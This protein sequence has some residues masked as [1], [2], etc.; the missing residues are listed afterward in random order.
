M[1][2][3]DRLINTKKNNN[4]LSKEGLLFDSSSDVSKFFFDGAEVKKLLN[5]SFLSYKNI[6]YVCDK[7][8]DNTLIANYFY[9]LSNLYGSTIVDNIETDIE[10]FNNRISIIPNPSINEIVKIFEYILCGYKSFVFGLNLSSNLKLIN[11][12]KTIIAINYPNLTEVNINTLLGFSNSLFV[13]VSVNDDGLYYVSE[14]NELI[15]DN[16]ELNLNN[17]FSVKKDI[18]VQE[19]E[20]I[21]AE[22]KKDILV[23]INTDKEEDMQYSQNRGEQ[24]LPIKAKSEYYIE[25]EIIEDD[26][27]A[28]EIKET[29][30]NFN[31][32]QQEVISVL[33]EDIENCSS[34]FQENK[35]QSKVNKYKLLKEKVKNKRNI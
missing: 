20:N 34:D 35:V 12:L 33:N 14:I 25:E 18:N 4:L 6:I 22:D 19:I 5:A 21:A 2:L 31:E 30:L 9:S 23:D 26:E 16:E 10:N 8:I 15:Y 3:K 13:Y 11:K 29:S 7:S 28:V 17:I 27:V 1:N 24:V 32:N